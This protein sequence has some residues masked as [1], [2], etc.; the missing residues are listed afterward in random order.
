MER[1]VLGERLRRRNAGLGAERGFAAFERAVH[2]G[3]ER[4]GGVPARLDAAERRL[5]CE[6]GGI[7][8]SAS[9]EVETYGGGVEKV[10]GAVLKRLVLDLPAPRSFKLL[11]YRR[12][13]AR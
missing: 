3:V 10:N 8:E 1:F 12:L 5:A 11:F 4:R 9:Y 2:G 6:L 7:D 13:G